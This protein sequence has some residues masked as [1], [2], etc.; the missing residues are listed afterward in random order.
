MR[1]N[2]GFRLSR[3][4]HRALTIPDII[5]E[6]LEKIVEGKGGKRRAKSLLSMAHCCLDFRSPSLDMLW[7]TMD[8]LDPLL[9]LLTGAL[10]IQKGQIV[11]YTTLAR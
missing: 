4:Q 1:P 2:T 11:R 3:T 6:I 5:S 10:R 7:K 8:S 9:M